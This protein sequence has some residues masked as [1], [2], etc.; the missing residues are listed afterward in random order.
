M[1]AQKDFIVRQLT[2]ILL[3]L[4][5]L[6]TVMTSC[7]KDK[8]LD[9]DITKFE[10]KLQ[11][12]RTGGKTLKPERKDYFRENPFI[13]KFDSDTTFSLN[14]SV[15]FAKGKYQIESKGE[16]L[17][18]TYGESTCVGTVDTKEQEL[19]QNLLYVF[20][21]VKKYIVVGETLLFKGT[22]GEVE[23]KEM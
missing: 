9:I 13:L 18:F 21:E 17:I 2:L 8:T 16:I 14:T 5:P 12:I 19:N 23:F 11:E 3:I 4:F 6:I 10:W 15:N 7:K 22:K 20:K 1:K